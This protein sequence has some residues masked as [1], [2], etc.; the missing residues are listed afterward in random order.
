VGVN[1]RPSLFHIIRRVCTRTTSARD[2]GS[3]FIQMENGT[4]EC[5]IGSI[6]FGC[7]LWHHSRVRSHCRHLASL[8]RRT[9]QNHACKRLVLHCSEFIDYFLLNLLCQW[10]VLRV[11]LMISMLY[12]GLCTVYCWGAPFTI[13]D[14]APLWKLVLIYRHRWARETKLASA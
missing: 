5:G 11:P 13:H 8:H 2:L 10:S 12:L 6:S 9:I 4:S 14:S 3:W 7:V 1:R